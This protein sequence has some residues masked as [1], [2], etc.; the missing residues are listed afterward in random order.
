[1]KYARQ[2]VVP[3]NPRTIAQQ[4]VRSLFAYLREMWKLA[5][6]EVLATW[7]DFAAGRPFTGMNK[8]VGENVRVMNGETDMDNFIGSPGSRGGLPAVSFAAVTGGSAGTIDW[9][10]TPPSL[11]S[12]WTIAKA[13]AVAFPDADPTGIFSGP[14][15]QSTDATSTYGG[16]LS[17]LGSAIPCQVSGWLVWNKPD[18]K[19]AY[20]VGTTVQ[21]TS[22]S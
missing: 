4:N 10:L 18:G 11:P 22:D 13:V 8:F 6:A 21:A 17:G 14:F 16:T 15:V 9:T 7:D 20:S 19:L 5:P 2:H 12:G 1:V 3:A